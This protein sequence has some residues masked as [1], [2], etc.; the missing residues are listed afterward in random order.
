MRIP[1]HDEDELKI[2]SAK[3][4]AIAFIIIAIIYLIVI[5]YKVCGKSDRREELSEEFISG[6]LSY[7]YTYD[8]EYTNS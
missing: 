4:L 2:L 3:N 7:E 5:M 8:E 1:S 6:S